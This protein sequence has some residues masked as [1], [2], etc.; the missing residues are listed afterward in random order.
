M[1]RLIR[2]WPKCVAVAAVCIAFACGDPAGPN[3]LVPTLRIQ[4]DT[5]VPGDTFHVTVTIQNPT[6]DT[7]AL[8]S[9]SS[10]LFVLSVWR[11]GQNQHFD[12]TNWGCLAVGRQ[13][14]IAPGDLLVQDHDLV[15]LSEDPQAPFAYVV[16]P[17]AGDYMVRA[18]M[19]VQLPDMEALLVVAA[20]AP[21]CT[22]HGRADDSC[23]LS[24]Q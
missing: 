13:F 12:G 6:R 20:L 1:F 17:P 15:A 23:V 11:D 5:V 4:P 18:R 24:D 19:E 3:D 10:C 14:L 21:A 2:Q 8:S 7:V 22:S 9:G 16:P